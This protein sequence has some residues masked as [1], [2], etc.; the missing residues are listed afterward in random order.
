MNDETRAQNAPI[1]IRV[2]FKRSPT[3][4]EVSAASYE[5]DGTHLKAKDGNANIVAD[6]LLNEVAG[7]WVQSDSAPIGVTVQ[8]VEARELP[9]KHDAE[10]DSHFD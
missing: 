9:A 2:K 1:I 8:F 3:V 6:F 4:A 7:W 5:S 10:G